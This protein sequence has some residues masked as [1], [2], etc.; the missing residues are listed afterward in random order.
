MTLT[1]EK[2]GA[3]TF[4]G[5]PVTLLGE[6]ILV[7]AQAPDFRVVDTAFAPVTLNDSAGKIRLIST[8]PSLDTGPCDLTTRTFNQKAAQLPE[9]V[10]IYTVSLDLPPAQKRWCGNAGIERIKTL[11]DYQDRSFGLNYGVLI[12]ELKLLARAVF[13]IDADGKVAYREIV[14][15]VAEQP[16]FDAALE[17]VQKLL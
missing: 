16:N 1:R 14:P 10:E 2:Q 8:V 6:D 12:K 17:A 4:K 11:S 13:V 15:E 9:K 5:N 3:V 7:G